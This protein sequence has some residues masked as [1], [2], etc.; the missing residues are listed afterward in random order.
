MTFPLPF[1]KFLWKLLDLVKSL[2]NMGSISHSDIYLLSRDAVET[3]RYVHIF[4]YSTHVVCVC[5]TS[6]CCFHIS[7][8]C[9]SL[10]F[11]FLFIVLYT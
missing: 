1:Q 2:V 10:H 11:I 5:M 4:Y 9:A 8:I 3:K 7:F 6:L